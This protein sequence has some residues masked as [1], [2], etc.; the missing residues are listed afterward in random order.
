MKELYIEML[1]HFDLQNLHNDDIREKS[2]YLKS[3]AIIYRK[4]ESLQEN[5][6]IN[7]IAIENEVPSVIISLYKR[8][9]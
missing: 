4:N 2:N 8:L 3:K 6:Q 7:K 1:Y 5:I 9:K